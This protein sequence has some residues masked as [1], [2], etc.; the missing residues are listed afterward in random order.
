MPPSNHQAWAG[1]FRGVGFMASG[2]RELGFPD[3]VF[4]RM[5]LRGGGPRGVGNLVIPIIPL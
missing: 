5:F 1:G 3:S 2:C 4:V